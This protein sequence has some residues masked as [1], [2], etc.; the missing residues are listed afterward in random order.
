[1]PWP[2]T[3]VTRNLFFW[4]TTIKGSYATKRMH[5]EKYFSKN[6][7]RRYSGFTEFWGARA[8]KCPVNDHFCWIL[9]SMV[10]LW[11][12]N[13]LW[14][15]DLCPWPQIVPW[16]LENDTNFKIW[17]TSPFWCY[18]SRW[19][20]IANYFC[21][22]RVRRNSDFDWQRKSLNTRQVKCKNLEK[23]ERVRKDN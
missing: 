22:N 3:R 9:R 12:D 11:D 8:A 19:K 17:V 14:E 18:M 13:R 10:R 2:C 16:P 5:V 23:Y 21:K 6:H 1:M 4:V 20:H 15:Y 7:T